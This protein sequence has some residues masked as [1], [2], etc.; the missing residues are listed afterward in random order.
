MDRHIPP[1]EIIDLDGTVRI[2]DIPKIL[3]AGWLYR[4]TRLSS[5]Y[6]DTT[7]KEQFFDELQ[8]LNS[9]VLKAVEMSDLQSEY[10]DYK[11]RKASDEHLVD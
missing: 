11:Q 1:N 7:L 5:M 2:A 9:L 8:N 10:E 3:N 4:L 6:A